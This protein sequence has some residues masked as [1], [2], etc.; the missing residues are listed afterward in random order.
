MSHTASTGLRW[1]RIV[2]LCACIH[3]GVWGAFIIG[4]PEKSARIYGFAQTPHDLHLWRGTGLFIVLLA[5]GYALAANNVQQHWGSVLI[6]LLAKVL[7]SIGMCSAA[8]QGQVSTR[9]L[10]LLPVNDVIWWLPFLFIVRY[11]IQ[12]SRR[13]KTKSVE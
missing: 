5:V 6:G 13:L 3:S 11:G 2:L 1:H 12:Q 4:L 8:L 7:G 9:V 10:W